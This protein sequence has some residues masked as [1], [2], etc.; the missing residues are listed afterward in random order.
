MGKLRACEDFRA[1]FQ[2]FAA[3]L[4]PVTQEDVLL[5]EG[6]VRGAEVQIDGL[7]KYIMRSIL[8]FDFWVSVLRKSPQQCSL[9]REFIYDRFPR[10]RAIRMLF[11]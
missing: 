7:A 1:W 9:K 11:P 5:S 6:L 8:K 3:S 2:S 10:I 4:R